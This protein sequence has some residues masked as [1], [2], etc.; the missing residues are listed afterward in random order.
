MLYL[1][2]LKLHH[3]PSEVYK[4]LLVLLTEVFLGQESLRVY[5]REP[6]DALGSY[7]QSG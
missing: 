7:G 6:Y 4:C 1:T 2:A 5:T 3:N